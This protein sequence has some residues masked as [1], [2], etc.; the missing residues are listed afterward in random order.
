MALDV[1]EA[2]WKLQFNLLAGTMPAQSFLLALERHL[3][4]LQTEERPLFSLPNIWDGGFV[5]QFYLFLQE[6]HAGNPLVCLPCYTKGQAWLM[7][8]REWAV[9][10]V[11]GPS[12]DPY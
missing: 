4:L 10:L 2:F 9:N 5:L 1:Q 7:G 11:D 12:L 8:R 3:Q 6:P